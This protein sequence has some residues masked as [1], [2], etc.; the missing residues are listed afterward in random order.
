LKRPPFDLVTM[1]KILIVQPAGNPP[2]GQARFPIN[3]RLP[4]MRFLGLALAAAVP[5]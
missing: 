2:D 3:D 4:F 1:L 5:Q